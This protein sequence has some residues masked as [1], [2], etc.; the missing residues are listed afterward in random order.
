[1]DHMEGNINIHSLRVLNIANMGTH[2]GISSSLCH[3]SSGIIV[4]ISIILLWP[5][6]GDLPTLQLFVYAQKL[7]LCSYQRAS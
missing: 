2:M 4:F 1:M 7:S 3:A 5:H 6:K